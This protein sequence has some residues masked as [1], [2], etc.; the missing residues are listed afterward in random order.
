M[1]WLAQAGLILLGLAVL[2]GAVAQAPPL[3][4]QTSRFDVPAVTLRG[5][6]RGACVVTDSAVYLLIANRFTSDVPGCPQMVDSLGTDLA[7]GGGR[8]PG[9]GAGQ[10]PAVSAAWHQALSAAG[11]V[12]LTSKSSV[13]IPWNPALMAYFH[14]NFRPAKHMNNA[15]LYVRRGLRQKLQKLHTA[16]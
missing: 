8:R 14:G 15:T 13:R 11:W 3:N 12:L 16:G 5:V 1:P 9:S 7:L 2:V 10:D 4:R 6:P